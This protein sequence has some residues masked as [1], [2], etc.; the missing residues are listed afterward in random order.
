[1]NGPFRAEALDAHA[2]GESEPAGSTAV[3]AP[4]WLVPVFW[5]ALI[6]TAAQVA[7]QVA[8]RDRLAHV[9]TRSR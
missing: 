9:E 6:A 4:R 2:A 7:G 8:L 1:V 3:P 5:L